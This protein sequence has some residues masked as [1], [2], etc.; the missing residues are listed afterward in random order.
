V[1]DHLLVGPDLDAA[2]RE[3]SGERIRFD[4]RIIERHR[5]SALLVPHE[6]LAGRR[7]AHVVAVRA[8]EVRRVRHAIEEVDVAHAPPLVLVQGRVNDRVEHGGVGLRL[9]RHPLRGRRGRHREVRLELDPRGAASP[10][11]RVTPD[12][13]DAAAHV[14]VVAE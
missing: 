10:R 7:V 3:L 13:D 2:H 8:D 4:V 6:R 12:T 5:R 11:F 14:A 1:R 9:D